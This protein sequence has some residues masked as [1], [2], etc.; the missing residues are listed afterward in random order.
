MK[1]EET[2]IKTAIAI[3]SLEKLFN[4]KK[5]WKKI[6]TSINCAMKIWY[7]PVQ[8]KLDQYFTLSTKSTQ[9]ESK[10]F[11]LKPKTPKMLGENIGSF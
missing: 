10:T 6:S 1:S 8:M 3:K 7:P 9:N 2:Y 5:V 4:N 11:K